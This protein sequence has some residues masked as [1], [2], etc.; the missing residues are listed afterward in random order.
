MFQ[1]G[2]RRTA[3][4][5]RGVRPRGKVRAARAPLEGTAAGWARGTGWSWAGS[6]AD[7]R[8][9]VRAG[10]MG[11]AWLGTLGLEDKERQDWAVQRL[12][13]QRTEVL[14]LATCLSLLN[15]LLPWKAA[16]H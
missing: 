2:D 7:R 5:G 9:W 11:W 6:W 4:R 3:G 10:R 16:R 13:V 14:D 12:E 15:D 8:G 1:P